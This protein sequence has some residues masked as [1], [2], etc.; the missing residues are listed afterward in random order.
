MSVMSS[1][2]IALVNRLLAVL[3]L[4][5][6]VAP[7]LSAEERT[8]SP[9]EGLM[10]R[11]IGHWTLTGTIAKKATTH[12][13]EIDWVLH[14][15]YVRIHEVSRERDPSGEPEYEAWI[16]IVW[17]P[18]RSEYALLWLDN[19]AATDFSGEGV[20]HAKPEGERLPFLF[21]LGDGTGIRTTFAYDRVRDTWAW[22][23]QNL[24]GGG[25]PAPFADV[26]LVRKESRPQAAL[27]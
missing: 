1:R 24:D 20:G 16:Y 14:R 5:S 12:D 25:N 19:T 27:P 26:V 18:K 17:D 6:F 23:I 3:A 7:A 2:V 8:A 4:A 22:T 15:Q 10:D 11:M 9:S 13:L 21:K